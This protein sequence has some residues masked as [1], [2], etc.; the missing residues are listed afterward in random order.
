MKKNH[1]GGKLK[2]RYQQTTT[3]QDKRLYRE[4]GK[5]AKKAVAIAKEVHLKSCIK[6]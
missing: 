6:N 5:E 3:K 4:A 1:G 2:T